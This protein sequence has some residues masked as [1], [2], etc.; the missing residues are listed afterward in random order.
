[1]TQRPS[2]GAVVAQ[3]TGSSPAVPEQTASRPAAPEQT[4]SSPGVPQRSGSGTAAAAQEPGVE[5]AAGQRAGGGPAV[6]QRPAHQDGQPP[7]GLRLVV[8]HLLSG[9]AVA[10]DRFAQRWEPCSQETFL[11]TVTFARG[12]GVAARWRV[13]LQTRTVTSAEGLPPGDTAGASWEVVGPIDLWTHVVEGELSLSMAL[14]RRLLHYGDAG[15]PT[16]TM[17]NRIAMLTDLISRTA[18]RRARPPSAGGRQ[19]QG[20]GSPRPG[21]D[22]AAPAPRAPRPV[23]P[24]G[25][26]R[27]DGPVRVNGPVR[28]DP[29]LW[30]GPARPGGPMP[31]AGPRHAVGPRHANISRRANGPRPTD[32]PRRTDGPAWP[33][34][35]GRGRGPVP[36]ARPAGE[37]GVPGPAATQRAVPGQ[38]GLPSRRGP[39][40][41]QTALLRA[42]P[43]RGGPSGGRAP[44]DEPTALLR[45]AP[46]VDLSPAALPDGWGASPR[47]D[48]T[49]TVVGAE[50]SAEA[51]RR[52]ARPPG[53]RGDPPHPGR[54][55]FEPAAA[56]YTDLRDGEARAAWP[57]PGDHGGT[58]ARRGW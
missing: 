24:D 37:R 7:P 26:V 30:D 55:E 41:E 44:V 23:R 39:V 52:R 18:S 31:A 15:D 12:G 13:D 9:L 4:G 47:A 36:L 46:A 22:Q 50:E 11:V 34:G 58:R 32:G 51:A 5:P 38:A 10:N 57:V 14:Q 25:P 27:T 1:M 54:A 53:R 56:D 2:R 16:P 20:R 21:P 6:T 8:A 28:P 42:V 3:Q 29:V 48:A 43:G 45:A 49:I 33:D 19:P 40:D 17:L 35:P